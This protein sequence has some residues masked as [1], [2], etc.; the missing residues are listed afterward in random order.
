MI[1]THFSHRIIHIGL[2][3][4][5]QPILELASNQTLM[6]VLTPSCSMF[7]ILLPLTLVPV[8]FM[9]VNVET[10]SFA[11]LGFL[12]NLADIISAIFVIETVLPVL[13]LGNPADPGMSSGA[14]VF[15]NVPHLCLHSDRAPI[16]EYILPFTMFVSFQ[17]FSPVHH[18]V[19]SFVSSITLSQTVFQFSQI[20]SPITTDRT[21]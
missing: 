19:G 16:E 11:L 1:L 17:E 14:Q 5:C 18:S 12:V 21:G 7:Y 2:L 9:F 3:I 13:L 4:I 10:I 15:G 20:P 6:M 8:V